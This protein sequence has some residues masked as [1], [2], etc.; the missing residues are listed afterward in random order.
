[1]CEGAF[2]GVRMFFRY[3]ALFLPQLYGGGNALTENRALCGRDAAVYIDG[4]R[5]MQA[6]K[7]VLRVKG[8]IHRVRSCFCFEDAAHVTKSRVYRLELTEVR[9]LQPFENCNFYDLDNFTVTLVLDGKRVVLTGCV[10]D[11]FEWL[12]DSSRFRERVSITA[13]GMKTGEGIS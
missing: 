4:R 8:S 11:D 2:A 7:A 13:L 10:W 6:E 9:F 1:M 3:P 12:A 5:L